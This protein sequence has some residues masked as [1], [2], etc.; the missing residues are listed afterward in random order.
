[1]YLTYTWTCS[2]VLVTILDINQ[3][4]ETINN[5]HDVIHQQF[6]PF[7]LLH[8]RSLLRSGKRGKKNNINRACRVKLMWQIVIRKTN[9][10]PHS[11]ASDCSTLWSPS[12]TESLPDIYYPH[13]GAGSLQDIRTDLCRRCLI[14]EMS[15]WL[16]GKPSHEC[17]NTK[18][19][20]S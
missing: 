19:M 17:K 13:K 7:K 15:L 3:T 6:S 14:S 8:W 12:L 10:F 1:M 18:T 5:L 4:H 11:L 9:S 16:P 2:N 20:G